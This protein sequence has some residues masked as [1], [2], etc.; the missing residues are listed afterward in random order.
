M[1][2]GLNVYILLYNL[3][4]PIHA[5][6][7]YIYI[8]IYDLNTIFFSI[9]LTSRFSCTTFISCAFSISWFFLFSKN[10]FSGQLKI[11]LLHSIVQRRSSFSLSFEDVKAPNRA[12]RSRPCCVRAHRTDL[13]NGYLCKRPSFI[14]CVLHEFYQK[15]A[16]LILLSSFW[17]RDDTHC[18]I[19]FVTLAF[20]YFVISSCIPFCFFL[21]FPVWFFFSFRFLSTL[22]FYFVSFPSVHSLSLM[23]L[24]TSSFRAFVS[25]SLHFLYVL[26]FLTFLFLFKPYIA[27]FIV[28]F[29]CF[30]LLIVLRSMIYR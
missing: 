13:L 9:F 29:Q 2:D 30:A 19:S 23:W 18:E 14:P 4:C 17:S 21:S 28:V 11:L 27:V 16:S 26:F 10:Q 6:Y 22:A 7:I 12:T 1:C 5:Q 8:Y 3:S 15:N 20:F 25:Q 24:L